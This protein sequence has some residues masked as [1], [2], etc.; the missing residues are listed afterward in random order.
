MKDVKEYKELAQESLDKANA[1]TEGPWNYESERYSALCVIGVKP[2]D[3][4]WIAHCQPEFNGQ[5]NGRFIAHS[6]QAVPSLANAVLELCQRVEELE[7]EN[8]RLHDKYDFQLLVKR[9]EQQ[10]VTIDKLVKALE[11]GINAPGK[12][13]EESWSNWYLF[14]SA[15]RQCL[16]EVRGEK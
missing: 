6:R 1:A 4:R 15:A 2:F 9:D 14:N 3:D 10:Q 8:K 16:A 13:A 12:T 7:A 5:H 11:V